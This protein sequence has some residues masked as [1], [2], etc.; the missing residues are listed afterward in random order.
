M[1]TKKK[2]DDPSGSAVSILIL[3]NIRCQ[4]A[5]LNHQ[6]AALIIS[7]FLQM[8]NAFVFDVLCLVPIRVTEDGD[9]NNS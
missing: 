9:A 8:L 5:V 6:N 4:Y 1:R 2:R 3:G 7:S